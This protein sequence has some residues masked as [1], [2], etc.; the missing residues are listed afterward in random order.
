M[1]RFQNSI[2]LAKS[3]W[4]VLRDDKQLTLLPLLS[5]LSSLVLAVAVFLPI[6]LIV[7][8]GSGGYSGS[9]PLV[10]LLGFVGAIAFTYVV[11]FF[12]A[13]LVFAANQRFQGLPVTVGEAIQ[14]ARQR[15]HVLL[16][17]AVVSATVSVV[18]RAIEQRGGIFGRI[19]GSLAGVAWS[20]VTFLVLPV[21]VFEGIG[22]IA[23]VKRSGELFKRTWGENI[24]TN[25]G[26]GLVG[27]IAMF[28]G[29]IPLMLFLAIGGPIAVFGV[30]L[31]AVWFVAVMLVSATL[32]G[33]F[34]T[35]LY[36]Y[37]TGA[38]VPGFEPDQLQGS[39]RPRRGRASGFFGA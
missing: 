25:A 4:Q 39:F 6:G 34:Q 10:W 19:I 33:I 30:V 17:W 9:A 2:A 31:F 7:R 36:R 27:M 22:P 21:L 18:L 11:V 1:S 32:T 12:N 23:A 13:A 8:D 24:M 26:I 38:P 3:S 35:A 28:A 5:M 29:A 37:A 16:P 15:A 14:S 20:V